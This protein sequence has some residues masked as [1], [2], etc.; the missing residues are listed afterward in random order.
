VD[1]YNTVKAEDDKFK[2][3]GRDETSTSFINDL[4]VEIQPSEGT[5]VHRNNKHNL[6]YTY[7]AGGR[8]T[9]TYCVIFR[10]VRRFFRGVH[11]DFR[12]LPFHPLDRD[13]GV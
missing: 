7:Y 9:H 6:F 13:N 5:A 4:K 1:R 12:Y 10:F 8:R 2:K 11:R 3:R